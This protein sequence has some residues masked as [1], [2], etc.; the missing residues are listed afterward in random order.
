[1]NSI[2]KNK[3]IIVGTTGSIAAY[4]TPLLVRELVKAGADVKVIMTPSANHF[5]SPL[6]LA[7]LS[8]NPVIIEMFEESYQTEGAWHINLA[9]WADAMMI[10][11]CSATTLSRIA[12]GNCDIPLSTLTIALPREI[13]LLIAPAMDYNMLLHP[14]TQ[15]N[16]EIIMSFGAIIIPPEEGELSSGLNGPGRLPDTE[17]LMNYLIDSLSK[18]DFKNKKTKTVNVKSEV[19]TFA[20]KTHEEKVKEALSKPSLSLQDAV[21]KDKWTAELELTKL[22]NPIN[23]EHDEF[24]KGKKVLITA[25][26]T[27]EKIDDVRF[28]SNYS[29]GKMGFAL[30]QEA[31][32]AGAEVTLITGP[33]EL[34][35][36][37]NVNRIDVESAKE[38][39]D[40]ALRYFPDMDI[41]ILAAAVADFSP[42]NYT[43][44][45][46]KKREIGNRLFL[47]L[48]PT[49]DIL[50]TFGNMKKEN[51]KLVGFA[52]ESSNEISNGWEKLH[53]KKCDMIVVNSL[54]KP[55]S[56]FGGDYNTISILIDDGMEL[57]FPPMTKQMC[58]TLILK[59]ISE[60]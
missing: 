38:M 23:S 60:L 16:I 9:H 52:L 46:I 58:A 51:Q 15:K 33:V 53:E 18:T 49:K 13:P 10:A 43:E 41:S 36:P 57:S 45:K 39:Y 12:T 59:K 55:Q 11:P 22:K 17:V 56:G 48:E 37:E 1:M 14:A 19:N 21:E 50:A 54:T 40:A 5:V 34:P 2:L 31:E 26:P 35:T 47:E 6:V 24:L 4:K 44:G 25:G 28:I 27:Y 29:S 3:K 42:V 20:E 32:I 7:N 8:R 30:A